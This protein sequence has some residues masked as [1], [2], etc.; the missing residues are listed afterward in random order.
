M[1]RS[2]LCAT[3]FSRGASHSVATAATW[4]EALGAS[5]EVLHVVTPL[6]SHVPPSSFLEE[7]QA[8]VRNDAEGKLESLV[9]PLLP[10]VKATWRV[11]DGFPREEIVGRART[12]EADLV[13]VGQTSET[14]LSRVVLGSVADRV[15]R[16]CDAAVLVVPM[17]STGALPRAIV[18][19]TDL[20]APSQRAVS[21]A[22]E[23]GRT[24]R[25]SVEVVHAYELPWL[26]DRE[27]PW[28]KDLPRALGE[29]ARA[30]HALDPGAALHVVEG[31]PA[32]AIAEVVRSTSANLVVIASSGRAA[33]RLLGG[34]TDRVL[35]SAHEPVLV[36]HGPSKSPRR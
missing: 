21:A 18:A 33:S 28:A 1:F 14:P 17:S 26:A 13:V 16:T 20:S 9:E 8:T 7:L 2:I 3:D 29:K 19:P 35:R 25:A 30:T 22:F 11:V 24:F 5:L 6:I 10:R 4:A 12:L 27:A 34:V 32:A 15:V 36:L 31:A 23:L